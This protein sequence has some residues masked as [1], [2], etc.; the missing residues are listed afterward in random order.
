MSESK[1][2]SLIQKAL[3]HLALKFRIS[4]NDL[5]LISNGVQKVDHMGD[6]ALLFYFNIMKEGHEFY[7]STKTW[8]YGWGTN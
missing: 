1:I 7:G 5:E 6:G 4:V 8:K 2:N 3:K